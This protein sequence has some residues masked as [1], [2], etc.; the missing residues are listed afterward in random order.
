M[1]DHVR[2]EDEPTLAVVNDKES[3][4]AFV[5]SVSGLLRYDLKTMQGTKITHNPAFWVYSAVAQGQVLVTELDA[6]SLYAPDGSVQECQWQPHYRRTAMLSENGEWLGS[7]NFP[8]VEVWSL[9][10]LLATC[11][12]QP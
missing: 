7:L 3:P 6:S 11:P 9:K 2:P 1:L 4:V 5:P 10:K 12:R 8:K